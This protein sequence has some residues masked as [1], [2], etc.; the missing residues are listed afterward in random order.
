MVSLRVGP[1]PGGSMI[2][3]LILPFT[4]FIKSADLTCCSTSATKSSGFL[5]FITYSST[6]CIFLR[7]GILLETINITGFSSS[8]LFF[9]V[10]VAKYGDVSPDSIC[11]PST[12]STYVSSVCDSSIKT[13]P[14][15]PTFL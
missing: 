7:L 1:K 6:L 12:T 13:T 2:F 5:F 4:L 10:L 9:S 8:H 11:T 14:F 15:L 3:T